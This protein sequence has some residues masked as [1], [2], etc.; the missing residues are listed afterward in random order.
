[1]GSLSNRTEVLTERG[2]DT[3]DICTEKKPKDPERRWLSASQE[4]R[5]GEIKVAG[6]LILNFQPPEL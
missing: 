2:R 4:E 5:P 6:T 3:K 1:M